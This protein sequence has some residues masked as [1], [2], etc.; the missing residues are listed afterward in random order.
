MAQIKYPGYLLN[1]GD[2]FSVDPE[3]VM[4][5]TGMPNSA[6]KQK[7]VYN[8]PPLD[9]PE[10]FPSIKN[11]DKR[12]EARRQKQDQQEANALKASSEAAQYLLK[13]HC[14]GRDLDSAGLIISNTVCFLKIRCSFSVTA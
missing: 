3:L 11:K 6:S 4:L 8:N 14:G 9:A 5:S 7:Y 1:P 13:Q 10:N 2:M 12:A